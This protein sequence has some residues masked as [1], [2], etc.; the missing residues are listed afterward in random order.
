M[1]GLFVSYGV[2]RI[3]LPHRQLREINVLPPPKK[4]FVGQSLFFS[5]LWVASTAFAVLVYDISHAI[6]WLMSCLSCTV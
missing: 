2:G 1:A 6:A 5:V 4:T 3:F